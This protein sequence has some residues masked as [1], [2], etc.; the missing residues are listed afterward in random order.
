MTDFG[1]DS[2]L[3]DGCI[4]SEIALLEMNKFEYVK[5]CFLC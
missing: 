5:I 1:S 2:L 4:C 3:F